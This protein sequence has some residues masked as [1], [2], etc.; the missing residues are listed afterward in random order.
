MKIQTKILLGSVFFA[1]VPLIVCAIILNSASNNAKV[2][3]QRTLLEQ[4]LTKTRN[5]HAARIESFFEH[6]EGQILT[7]S[8]NLMLV[9]AMGEFSRAYKELEE[10]HTATLATDA[11]ADAGAKLQNENSPANSPFEQLHESFSN[12]AQASSLS[13]ENVTNPGE[14]GKFKA[15]HVVYHPVLKD[16]LNQFG[17]RDLYLVDTTND[18]VVYSVSKKSDFATSLADGA[19][20]QSAL[21]QIY[22]NEKLAGERKYRSLADF[23]PYSASGN[24]PSLFVAS[25]V[26][27]EDQ[28]IGVLIFELGK[29]HIEALL[30]EESEASFEKVTLVNEDG[31]LPGSDNASLPTDAFTND[32]GSASIENDRGEHVFFSYQKLDILDLQWTVVTAINE[33]QAISSLFAKDEKENQKGVMVAIASLV[34]LLPFAWLYS[35]IVAEPLNNFLKSIN[36]L[37]VTQGDLTQRLS[38][39]GRPEYDKLANALNEFMIDLDQ[40]FSLFFQSAIRLVPMSQELSEGNA[41]IIESANEQNTQIQKVRDRLSLATD[42]SH[43]VEQGS[44]SILE[45]SLSGAETVKAGSLEFDATYSQIAELGK[46]MQEACASLDHLKEESSKINNVIAVINAIAEQTDL[47]ALNAAIEAA[48]A[49]EAGRGFA[50]VADEVRALAS[51]TRDATLEVSDMVKAIAQGTH[52][53][54]EIMSEG[55]QSTL[56]CSETIQVAKQKLQLIEGAMSVIGER[57]NDISHSIS[58]QTENFQA[59]SE[60][61]NVLDESFQKSQSA[62]DITVQIGEDMAKLSEKLF[63]IIEH[64]KLTENSWNTSRRSATRVEKEANSMIDLF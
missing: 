45:E 62:N 55:E 21:A 15:A 27:K 36:S 7:L 23:K 17:Y 49:G 48:R 61:F 24:T 42:S 47:L 14:L 63:G 32:A 8:D 39:T 11:D 41:L 54:S 40:T 59:A 43:R 5:L 3:T 10:K 64:F 6:L 57:V 20:S 16:F 53:V 4:S 25:S 44:Q 30:A 38:N 35:R 56:K 58:Q 18:T 29:E 2:D 60:D 13:I 33:T 34:T 28:K 46:T 50:V 22:Q 51:R 52:T 9:D 37:A 12:S 1:A 31:V 19:Y 26:F